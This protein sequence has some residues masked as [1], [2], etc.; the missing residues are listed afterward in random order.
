[1]RQRTIVCPLIQN[2][3]DYLLCKMADDRGVFP[4]QWALSGGGVEPGERIEDTLRREV[5]EELGKKLV[6]QQIT[7]WT[8]SDDV[9]IKTY[10][11]GS[12][13]EIYMIYLIFDCI[14]ANRE[15]VINEEFQDYAW[16]SPSDLTK[17]DLNVATR[18]TL[19][20]KGL[21]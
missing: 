19:S 13:E 17:Y 16:V 3:G 5:R 9:R 12:K 11:D 8:F 15:V 10:A 20:L 4:G 14:S 7:P 1:M 2:E 21:L 6:L 18:R